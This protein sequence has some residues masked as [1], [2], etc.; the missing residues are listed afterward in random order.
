MTEISKILDISIGTLYQWFR[1]YR[2][3]F[4][5][6][7]QVTT[8]IVKENKNVHKSS[9]I[10]NYDKIIVNYVDNNVGCSLND[11]HLHLNKEISITSISRILKKN[12]IKR[13]KINTRIVAKD[14]DKIKDDSV[15]FATKI[16]TDNIDFNK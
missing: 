3:Y 16:N 14:L 12:K 15:N 4:D 2:Y 11:I 5:N 8:E 6:N 13:K 7:I 9:K 10:H 1:I